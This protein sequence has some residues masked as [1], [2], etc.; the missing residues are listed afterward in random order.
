MA[1]VINNPDRADSDSGIG[2]IAGVV[3]ALA[4][5]ILAA[6]YFIPALRGAN[7]GAGGSSGSIPSQVDVNLNAG[8]SAG[9]TGG[10]TSGQ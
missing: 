7:N 4:V 6:L 1:T 2:L 9:G 10:G 5:L 8:G 3:I